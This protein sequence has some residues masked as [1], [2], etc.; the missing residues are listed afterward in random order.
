ME[1][2]IVVA[3]LSLLAVVVISGFISLRKQTAL[4]SAGENIMSVLN[5]ARSKTLASKDDSEYGVHFETDRI[6]LFKGDVFSAADPDN[7]E[8][9]VLSS[10]EISNIDLNGG[11]SDLVFE[12]LTGKTDNNGTTTLR[13]KSDFSKTKDIVISSTGIVSS[14]E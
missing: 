13:L 14:Q 11:G 2:L 1:I 3:I 12:R 10:V 9:V 8:F 4:D 6:V 7:K 5:E